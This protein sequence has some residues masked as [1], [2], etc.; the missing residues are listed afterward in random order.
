MP[1]SSRWS[2]SSSDQLVVVDH[3]VV[4]LR[5]PPAGLAD[6]L[7]LRMRPVVHVGGVHP[8][9]ERRV[10]IVCPTNEVLAG[11]GE[12][13]VD[14]FHALLGQRPGVLDA[15]LA[16]GAAP[17]VFGVVELVG[18]PG[19]DDPARPQLLVEQRELVLRRPVR[20]L[21][22]LLCVEVVQVAE[23]LVEAVHGGQVL[24]LVP[25]V[26]L[27][28]LAGG[29]A[30]RLQQLGDRRVLLLQTDGRPRHSDLGHAGAEHALSGDERRPPGGAALLAVGVGETH[31]LVGDPVDVGCSVTHQA[32][33]VTAQVGDADVVAPDDQD[34]R[35]AVGHGVSF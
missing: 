33:A 32:V 10:G 1:S 20:V 21:W 34:V 22:L 15:L 17:A 30:V 9:E 24:V 29:V 14:G 13:L 3:R 5:L 31:P 18:R 28:E 35:F 6:A 27:A 12:F 8:D 7:R 26:V 11:V 16:A 19:V 23:E 4:V 25:E 2:S